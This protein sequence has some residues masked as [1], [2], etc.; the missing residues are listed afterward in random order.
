MPFR[1]PGAILAAGAILLSLACGGGGGTGGQVQTATLAYVNPAGTGWRWVK[2]EALS[3]PDRLVLAL[4][5]PEGVTGLRG[6]A[7]SL[8]SDPAA[9]R[10][11]EV[12][13]GG[14]SLVENGTFNL[15]G[16]VPLF[17][18]GQD[19]GV[20]RAG[21]FQ[22]GRGDATIPDGAAVRVALA[23][24]AGAGPGTWTLDRA[25]LKVLPPTGARLVETP[26][27]AGRIT[28]Q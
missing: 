23:V 26:V 20:L 6:V 15:G 9:T 8:A 14:R 5:P 21:I 4:V 13:A 24:Q 18:Y 3:T 11:V 17:R 7:F 10:W 22:K 28:V 19:Q 1:F 25:S 12:R 16:G 27:E 2:D